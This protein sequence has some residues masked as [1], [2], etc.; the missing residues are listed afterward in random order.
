MWKDQKG[1]AFIAYGGS[2]HGWQQ[3]AYLY[4][5]Q[6]SL[7]LKDAEQY[8]GWTNIYFCPHLFQSNRN[9]QKENAADVSVLW[10]DQD[11]GDF[12]DIV[13][14]PTV[15][16]ETSEGKHHAIW[17]LD[18][19][20]P[21]QEAEQ[22]VK[23]LTYKTPG[24]DRG[25]WNLGRVIRFPGSLNYKYTPPHLGELLWM[26]GPEYLLEDL[27]PAEH[28]LDKAF[29][30][31]LEPEVPPIPSIGGDYLKKTLFRYGANIPQG[32]WE[33]LSRSPTDQDDVSAGLWKLER[34]MLEAGIPAK[35]VFAVVKDSPWNKYA[36]DKR[37]VAHLWA[38]VFKASQEKGPFR[39]NPEDL[40]WTALDE[41]MLYSERPE[42]LVEGI[43]MEKNVG[44][45]A[46]VG[47][48]YKSV[49]ST[50]LALS[51]ASGTPFLGRYEV[52]DPGPVLM[53]QEEDPI[54]RVAHRLQVICQRKGLNGLSLQGKQSSLVLRMN[55]TQI[56]LYVSI[57]GGLTFD[58]PNRL[59]AVERALA[60]YKP[61]L[62]VLDPLFMMTAGMDDF[63]ASDISKALITIKDW[64]NRY[65]C[66]IAI[67]HHYR[68][69]TGS[70]VEKL[71]GSQALYAWSE[72]NLFVT[73]E[74]NT[75]RVLIERDIKDAKRIENNIAV[76]FNDIDETYDF[77]VGDLT[78]ED[79]EPKME[80]R[81][82]I[83]EDRLLMLLRVVTQGDKVSF[84]SLV[85][86]SGY[87]YKAARNKLANFEK[88]GLVKL[89]HEGQ[90]GNLMVEPLPPLF[91]DD[92]Q[93]AG[94]MK[95]EGL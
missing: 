73:R 20:Y 17:I 33:M 32:A 87:S 12:R 94:G 29:D 40:P 74:E 26:D 88:K 80:D 70:S 7:M 38:E 30:L 31:I 27:A 15:C 19:P 75:N 92:L 59:E 71:Y 95:M 61:K 55:D 68:K 93:T 65:G 67:V 42:W 60:Y 13:P 25:C 51:V 48:S 44:W 89:S 23:Y 24:G 78:T 91:D 9:K 82:M 63:K 8:N 1:Y 52:N 18:K 3:K 43:W 6:L 39:D 81:T 16:W 62:I 90:G 45:I 50:D 34:L 79:K 4:P 5:D 85:K 21:A 66:A 37:P 83:T 2:G 11:S 35:Q 49:I 69:G 22:L 14:K 58:S 53:I 84:A 86:S 54:W 10:I 57:S 36:R 72:N 56:P 41:L 47:K 77:F 28:S 46:G 64:R 76:M